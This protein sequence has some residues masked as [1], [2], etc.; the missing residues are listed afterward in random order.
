MATSSPRILMFGYNGANNTGAEALLLSDIADV[1]AVLGP[2]AELTVPT[3]NEQNL[4]RYLKEETYLRI[5]PIP[6]VYFAAV[7]RLVKEHDV[8]ML[9]EGST[10]MDTWTSA[11][12]WA[13]LWATRCADAM[14]KPSLAYAVDAGEM[15][16][17][18][19]RCL[20]QREASKTDLIVVRSHAARERLRAWGVSAPVEVTADN[21]FTFEPDPA[22]RNWVANA[23]P[24]A[25]SGLVGLAVVDFYLWPVV[26]R[27]FGK[28]SNCYRWPYFYS[29]SKRRCRATTDLTETY[30]QLADW[31]VTHCGKHVA[32]ICMEQL[33]EPLA[34]NIHDRMRYP[35]SARVFSSREHTASRMTALLS[36]LDLLIT[37]RYHACV[38]S[39]ASLVP[40]VAV[41]HDLRL[42]TIYTDLGL[43]NDYFID[44]AEPLLLGALQ[45]RLQRILAEPSIQKEALAAGHQQH[46]LRARQNR[47]Y[48]KEFLTAHGWKTTS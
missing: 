7:K 29:R 45:E 28:Q 48:L 35:E 27:L 30:A 26:V 24:G 40:Q 47:A 15:R 14:A 4:R 3:L 33:D 34:R 11:L 21:A 42:K 20:V 17:A 19:N 2:R 31:I 18:L 37:S 8:L 38:L 13:F 10:Y 39:L 43:Y 41:G 5:A 23:W 16:S 25:A 36:D 1:R 6:P 44:C 12:L 32:L 46:L 22:D 9:V